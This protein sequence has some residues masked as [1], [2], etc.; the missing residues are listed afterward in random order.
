M[1]R[2]IYLLG[3]MALFSAVLIN[4]CKKDND[5][6]NSPSGGTSDVTAPTITSIQDIST[7]Q[8]EVYFSET[9]DEVSA[10]NASNYSVS[11]AVGA[12]ISATLDASNHKLVHLQFSILF[13]S[14]IQYTLTV[15]NVKDAAGNTIASNSTATFGSVSNAGRDAVIA[16]YNANYLGSAVTT[17]GWTGSIASC[18]AGTLP[19]A[20]HNAVIK[21]INY[22]RRIVGLNDNCTLNTSLF[23][24]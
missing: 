19:Q 14:G 3:C 16:D 8:I 9:V 15:N 5:D 12:A 21:R 23:A 2:Q 18:N 7:I 20:T 4:G 24:Q 13:V 10:E 17:L 1:R 22:F 11:P 6:D